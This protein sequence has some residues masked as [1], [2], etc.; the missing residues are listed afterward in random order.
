MDILGNSAN[1]EAIKEESGAIV[2]LLTQEISSINR[3]G[4]ILFEKLG[5]VAKHVVASF[6]DRKIKLR[7]K[8]SSLYVD[9]LEKLLSTIGSLKG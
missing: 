8:K 7:L 2:V 6:E 9:E 1:I 3:I 5:E 4:I